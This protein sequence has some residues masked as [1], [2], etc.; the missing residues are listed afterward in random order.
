MHGEALAPDEDTDPNQW[1]DA[2][3]ASADAAT[4]TDTA[5]EATAATSEAVSA[6]RDAGREA[7]EAL[8]QAEDGEDPRDAHAKAAKHHA[9]AAA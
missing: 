6:S 5:A 3:N 4:Q 9:A 8:R 2:Q 7:G 1:Q